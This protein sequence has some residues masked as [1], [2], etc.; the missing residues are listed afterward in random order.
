MHLLQRPANRQ[1]TYHDLPI[2]PSQLQLPGPPELGPNNHAR[3]EPGASNLWV[4]PEAS[5][6]GEPILLI[7]EHNVSS[8]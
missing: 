2:H 8:V 7:S 4:E 1:P 6:H 3:R 5:E